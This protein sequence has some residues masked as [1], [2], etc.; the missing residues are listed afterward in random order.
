MAKYFRH[1]PK[2]LYSLEDRPQS[3]DAVTNICTRFTFEKSFKENTGVYYEYQIQEGESAEMI[4]HKLYGSPEMHW[5]IFMLNDIIDPYYDWPM[6][7]NVFKQ[8]LNSKYADQA[9]P[10]STGSKWAVANIKSYYINETRTVL[11]TGAIV[12]ETREVDYETWFDINLEV[13]EITLDTGEKIRLEGSKST[14]TYYNYEIEENEKRRTLKLI[15]P[16]IAGT[17]AKQFK[18]VIA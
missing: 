14:K 2:E 11:K 3:L 5:V 1:Y 10:A 18:K 13:K 9:G 4:A 8:Y 15:K 7:S 17:L 16:E 12:F 6:N